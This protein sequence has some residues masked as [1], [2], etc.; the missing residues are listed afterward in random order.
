MKLTTNVPHYD[1]L[2]EL[3]T[4][5]TKAVKHSGLKLFVNVSLEQAELDGDVVYSMLSFHSRF[6]PIG[7]VNEETKKY[8]E[9]FCG[10]NV[11]VQED[12]IRL[13]VT[14]KITVFY[15]DDEKQV[16]ILH[17]LEFLDAVAASIV[18]YLFALN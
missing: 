18:N 9:T 6:K 14:N 15:C 1:K 3:V 12:I 2:I 16:D 5:K 13:A 11:M 10:R 8:L 4:E 17:E 7:T